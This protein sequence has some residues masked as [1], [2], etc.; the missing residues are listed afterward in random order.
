MQQQ[1]ENKKI[2]RTYTIDSK[3]E[4]QFSEATDEGEKSQ[5]LENFMRQYV[6]NNSSD[7]DQIEEKI[8]TLENDIYQL[9]QERS[10]IDE[11]IAEKKNEIIQ[12]ESQ[13]KAQEKKE[14]EKI[15]ID[16]VIDDHILNNKYKFRKMGSLETI[17]KERPKIPVLFENKYNIDMDRGKFWAKFEDR[18]EH[19]GIV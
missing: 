2:P 7:L 18:L 15:N 9:K 4:K 17:K 12:L 11:E 10:R 19:H 6:E 8:N 13:Q 5:L 16:E 1:D 3:I 14:K